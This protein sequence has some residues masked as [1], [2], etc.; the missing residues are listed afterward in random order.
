MVGTSKNGHATYAKPLAA[1]KD[2][3]KNDIWILAGQTI[4]GKCNLFHSAWLD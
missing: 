2:G 4:V 3:K 1:I